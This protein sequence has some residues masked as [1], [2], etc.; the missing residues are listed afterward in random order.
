[1][2]SVGSSTG[3]TRLPLPPYNT[4]TTPTSPHT[5][6]LTPTSPGAMHTVSTFPALRS[7]RGAAADAPTPCTPA[8][9][10]GS[11]VSGSLDGY[12]TTG[13]AVFYSP[14]NSDFPSSLGAVCEEGVSP[15]GGGEASV[16]KYS[17]QT[18]V[19]QKQLMRVA[20]ELMPQ[21]AR[22]MMALQHANSAQV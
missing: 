10:P 1:M 18:G 13:G 2:G 22:A 17:G 7:P 14:A 19:V 4:H 16:T 3:T 12:M 9:V 5:H 6:S 11:G 15:G 21:L 8:P 20:G